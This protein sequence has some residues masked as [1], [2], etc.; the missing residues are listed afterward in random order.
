MSSFQSERVAAI[1][2]P[3]SRDEAAV[4]GGRIKALRERLGASQDE[5]AGLGGQP[6]ERAQVARV[7]GGRSQLNS[8]RLRQMLAAGLGLSSDEFDALVRGEMT[9][10]EAYEIASPRVTARLAEYRERSQ[11]S[12]EA[13]KAALRR[14]RARHVL[15]ESVVCFAT[16]SARAGRALSEQDWE[17]ELERLDREFRR[18]QRELT[19]GKKIR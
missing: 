12:P 5:V 15:L 19:R 17:A 16:E 9:A 18:M 2:S 1:L 13:L 11:G 14:V 8:Y 7:E 3:V 6:K 10:D 4:A